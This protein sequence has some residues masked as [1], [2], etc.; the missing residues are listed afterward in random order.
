MREREREKEREREIERELRREDKIYV[1]VSI[2]G[3]GWLDCSRKEEEDRR[4]SL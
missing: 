3:A 1:T 2:E 4:K